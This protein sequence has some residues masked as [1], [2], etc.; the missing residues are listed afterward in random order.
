MTDL[1]EIKGLVEKINPVLTE[2]RSEVEAV[3]NRD[4]IDEAKFDKMVEKITA[5]MAELQAKNAKLEAAMKRPGGD[6]KGDN[7]ELLAKARDTFDAYA[8]KG[9]PPT[10]V[11]YSDTEGL[12]IRAMSTN[13]QPDG[14]YL[15]RPE[16]ANFVVDRVFETS[17]LRGVARVETIGSKS[18]DVLIDD[19][20][21]GARWAAEGPS[22]GET[23]TPQ[24]GQKEI[25]AHKLEADPKI[26]TEQLQDS[27]LDVEAWLGGKVADVFA[28]SE[29]TAF[30]TGNGVGK[31]RGFLTYPAWASAGVYERDKIERVKTGNATAITADG[32]I[33]LQM[34]LKEEYQARAVFGMKRVTF[35]SALKLKGADNYFFGPVLMRDGQAT[36]QL[37]GKPVIFMDDME[38]E[39]ANA[40][41]VVYADFS[42]A[43]TIVDRVGLQVLRD[44]Y[45]NK[46]FVTFYTTKRTGGDVTSFDAIKIQNCAA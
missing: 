34:S 40:L 46:G 14:G 22:G 8:R 9:T 42:R 13:V 23:S 38:L 37:L 18:L 28:R 16:L 20:Q 41:A 11:K 19:N 15:V 32:L 12:E 30:V 44:P 36:I 27:Y 29:N 2:L 10:D 1:S 17:P 33:N 7:A 39:G 25:V 26:T 43:Y 24:L 4:V 6:G 35:G 31:P 21:A 3:K 5:D 45:T